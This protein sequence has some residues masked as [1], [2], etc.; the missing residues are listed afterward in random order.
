MPNENITKTFE[1]YLMKKRGFI[2]KMPG[3]N[4]PV[5][6]IMSGGLD[7]TVVAEY[8]MKEHGLRIFPLFIRRGQRAENQEEKALDF[9]TKEFMKRNGKKLFN[10]PTKIE[11]EIPPKGI[12][13]KIPKEVMARIGHPMRDSTLQNFGI[14]YA[15]T[16]E[17]AYGLKVRTVFNAAHKGCGCS[18][19]PHARLLALRSQTI[20]TCIHTG[21]WSWQ[22]TSPMLDDCLGKPMQKSGLVAMG[23][24]YRLKLEK[25][26]SCYEGK[27][28]HCGICT[29]CQLRQKSFNEAKVQDKTEY[30][31]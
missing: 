15:A 13:E 20:N 3:K 27:E 26:W 30:L 18:D 10:K 21:D 17:S 4:E 11:T 5:V 19:F 9:F 22:I 14:Q 7:S 8:L 24:K 23:S 2:S 29:A 6:L 12:K 31:L 25:T 1:D 16:L 28:K